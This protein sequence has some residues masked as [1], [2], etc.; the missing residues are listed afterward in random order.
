MNKMH[1]RGLTRLLTSVH[2]IFQTGVREE[3][4]SGVETFCIAETFHD[5]S[6]LVAPELRVDTLEGTLHAQ[7]KV[8]L[9]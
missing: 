6:D 1:K 9:L 5:H 3:T 8:D 2:R 4:D 7:P